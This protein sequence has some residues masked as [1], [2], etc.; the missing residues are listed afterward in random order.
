MYTSNSTGCGTSY[1]YQY[2]NRVSRQTDGL[3]T[4]GTI[5]SPNFPG[6]YP[7]GQTCKWTVVMPI[8]MNISVDFDERFNIASADDGSCDDYLK[9]GHVKWLTLNLNNIR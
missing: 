3:V 1:N 7:P 4:Q 8:G 6:N 5:N 9:V 2:G